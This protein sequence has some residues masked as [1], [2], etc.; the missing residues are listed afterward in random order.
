MGRRNIL[1]ALALLVPA[2][3][4]IAGSWETRESMPSS[5]SGVAAAMLDGIVH[6][7]GGYLGPTNL[8]TDLCEAHDPA[9]DAWDS[10][11]DDLPVPLAFGAMAAVNGRLYFLGG[12][13]LDGAARDDRVY[14]YDPTADSWREVA[15]M[16][17]AQEKHTIIA[18]IEIYCQ[19]QHG[20]NGK[21]CP[22]CAKLLEY[23]LLRL[24]RCPFGDEKPVCSKCPVHCYRPDRRERIREVMRFAGP[25]SWRRGHAIDGIKHVIDGRRY[26]RRLERLQNQGATV[27]T[28]ASKERR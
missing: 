14:E 25:R 11:V 19:R 6:V 16:P 3:G 1:L 13:S 7:C 21:R 2:G 15:T 18:M 24:E 26:R 28:E 4:L 5:R 8:L 22:E 27:G 17:N 9:A 23:A 20:T 10:T 12:G